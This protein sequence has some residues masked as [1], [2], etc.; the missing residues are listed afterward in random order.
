[1]GKYSGLTRYER[2]TL[3][4]MQRKFVQ[5][6]LSLDEYIKKVAK[7]KRGLSVRPLTRNEFRKQSA[8][9]LGGKQA[10]SAADTAQ[11]VFGAELEAL[12]FLEWDAPLCWSDTRLM[13]QWLSGCWVVSGAGGVL[14]FDTKSGRECCDFLLER[15]YLRLNGLKPQV[16]SPADRVWLDYLIIA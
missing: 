11:L 5:S 12:G 3:L 14:L 15:E 13:V 10:W 8:N 9:L 16:P 1:M 6:H 4:G 7:D 2:D